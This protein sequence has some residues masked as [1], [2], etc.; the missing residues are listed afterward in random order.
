MLVISLVL[1]LFFSFAID[2]KQNQTLPQLPT[3]EGV[4]GPKYG[5]GDEAIVPSIV[6]GLRAIILSSW[7][8]TGDFGRDTQ[9]MHR[10]ALRLRVLE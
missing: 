3:S 6:E 7:T 2:P 4:Y 8:F 1:F 10:V 9:E 5:D